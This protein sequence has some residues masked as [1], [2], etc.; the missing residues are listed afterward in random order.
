[1]KIRVLTYNIHKGFS[2][3]NWRF[4]LHEMRE[5][6]REANAD[7][8]VMQEVQGEHERHSNRIDLWPEESQLEFLADRLWPHTAYGK[9]AVYQHGHHGN[10]ILSRFPMIEWENINVSA[11]VDASR[12]LLHGVI[13][14]VAGTRV[15]IICVHLGLFERE[16]SEQMRILTDRIES[17]VPHNE[18]LVI[19]GD[20]N[21]WRGHCDRYLQRTAEVMEVFE[22][23]TGQHAA[24][25]PSRFPL[26]RVDRIYCRGLNI[27]LGR[28]L[29]GY[30]WRRLSDHVPL[31]A[32]LALL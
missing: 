30:H 31:Y 14:P 1:M 3:G 26:L 27:E 12:S 8:V 17:H 25:F 10:A 4:V 22:Y 20:F 5:A 15:H 19:A 13:E 6:L 24:S 29:D 18:A 16:R 7:I 11:R 2:V 21:D 28:R 9:N 23:L 32:Q